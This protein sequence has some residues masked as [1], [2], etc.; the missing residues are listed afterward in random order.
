[1]GAASADKSSE[2]TNE[3]NNRFIS[4]IM[5]VKGWVRLPGA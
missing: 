5:E 1:M 2:K 3:E 4:K